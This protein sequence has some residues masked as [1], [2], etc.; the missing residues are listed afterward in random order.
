M[1]SLPSK[2]Q[3][4]R[5]KP[6]SY[7]IPL[8]AIGQGLETLQVGAF[9]LEIDGDDYLVR[10]WPKA[11]MWDG[12]S[13]KA[14]PNSDVPVAV[15]DFSGPPPPREEFSGVQ[16]SS[17]EM[18]LRFT[19]GD[20]EQLEREGQERRSNPHETPDGHSMPELLRATGD[21]VEQRDARLLGISWRGQ[22]ISIV[23]ET[24]EGRRELDVFSLSSM[25]DYWQLMCLR[26]EAAAFQLAARA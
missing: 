10:G 17:A 22:S 9:N 19:P 5:R 21:Y 24:A 3:K 15:E 1:G 23:Y 16:P 11:L 26:R 7:A 18:E 8:R 2:I 12:L 13:S 6:P 14:G 4:R 25:Y 20:I